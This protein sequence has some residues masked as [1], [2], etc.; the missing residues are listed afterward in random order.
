MKIAQINY[1]LLSVVI[2]LVKV[3]NVFAMFVVL[4]RV[5]CERL[6]LMFSNLKKTNKVL[7]YIICDVSGSFIIQVL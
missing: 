2:D 6:S 7:T 3:Q 4:F 1:L 5:C